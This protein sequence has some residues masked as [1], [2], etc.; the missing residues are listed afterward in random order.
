M[1]ESM[2]SV[3]LVIIV[4]SVHSMVDKPNDD[5]KDFHIPSLVAVGAALGMYCNLFPFNFL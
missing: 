5:L 4:E 3:S 2:A 1:F